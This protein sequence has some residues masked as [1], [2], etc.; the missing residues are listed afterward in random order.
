MVTLPEE[1]ELT[2]ILVEVAV[3]LTEVTVTL[4]ELV[5]LGVVGLI[6]GGTMMFEFSPGTTIAD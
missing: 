1:V 5:V 6:I 2:V 4:V 3:A